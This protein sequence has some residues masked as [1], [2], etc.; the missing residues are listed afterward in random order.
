MANTENIYQNIP[1]A[2]SDELFTPLLENKNIR[3]ER[4]VSQGQRT[5]AGE[6]YDQMQNEWVIVVQGQAVI[7]YENTQTHD[8]N[9]G[10]Y[11]FIPAGTRHRVLWTSHS[12]QTLWLAVHWL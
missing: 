8:L 12:E 1:Q 7:E 10:D 2:L 6:W 11:L 3:I 4:I 5:K 9:V